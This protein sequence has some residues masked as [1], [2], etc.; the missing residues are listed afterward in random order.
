MLPGFIFVSSVGVAILVLLASWMQ[1]RQFVLTSAIV[2]VLVMLA[3]AQG[4][5]LWQRVTAANR[6]GARRAGLDS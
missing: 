6:A 5:M 3:A 1:P 4:V 2:A